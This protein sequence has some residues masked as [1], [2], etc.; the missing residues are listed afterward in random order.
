MQI[1]DSGSSKWL[2]SYFVSVFVCLFVFISGTTAILCRLFNAIYSIDLCGGYACEHSANRVS[3]VGVL[4]W[5]EGHDE[6]SLHY[7]KR[8][9]LSYNT[10]EQQI[11]C[12]LT[13]QLN[14]PRPAGT[15]DHHILI[16]K[17]IAVNRGAALVSLY[18]NDLRIWSADLWSR[19]LWLR[20]YRSDVT[21]RKAEREF[22]GWTIRNS[23]L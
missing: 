22:N 16:V 14:E 6:I 4:F 15:V 7:R 23:Q 18:G 9:C 3:S 8:I 5:E 20:C 13:S 12:C 17:Q 1:I 19:K 11:F 10:H 2:N 21:S